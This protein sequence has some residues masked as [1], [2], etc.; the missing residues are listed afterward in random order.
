ML[1]TLQIPEIGNN[2]KGDNSRFRILMYS[3]QVVGGVEPTK[4]E[5]NSQA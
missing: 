1:N 3:D 2:N 4:P 5:I